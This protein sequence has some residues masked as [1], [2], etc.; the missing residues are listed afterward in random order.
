[1]LIDPFGRSI[2]Y[3]RISITDKCNL[4]CV[5]CLPAEG[6]QWFKDEELLTADEIVHV[7]ETAVS[8]GIKKIRLTGGEPLVRKDILEIV[9]RISKIPGLEDL[10]L[11]TNAVLLDKMAQ[12]LAEAGL[13]R[14]NISLDT[15]QPE[16]YQKITRLGNFQR[17]WQG[18]LAAEQAG[19]TPI[20]LNTVVVG[21]LN[22][23]EIVSIARLSIEHPWHIR[24]I[25]L[26]PV[27]NEQDWGIGL[28]SNGRRYFSVQKMHEA[29]SG[30]NLEFVETAARGPERTYRIPKAPGTVGFISP[31]GDHFCNQ[32]NRLRLT[33]DGR[34]RSCLLVDKEISIREVLNSDEDIKSFLI[35]ATAEKPAGHA[36]ASHNCPDSRCMAQ[37]GG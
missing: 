13:Q 33:A 27:A 26:M 7:A 15:L 11:T 23:D 18:I 28:P 14:V 1:M 30:L 3:L 35:K 29:L 22:D 10:S 36:L 12:P 16:K 32:C 2:T 25:E 8:L 4:R 6:I 9:S 31:L 34:L 21:G 5:Y 17:A 19:L 37:I 20:K 24:F